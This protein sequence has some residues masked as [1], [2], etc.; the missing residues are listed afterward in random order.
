M[1]QGTTA[2]TR[3]RAECAEGRREDRKRGTR[4][5]G[6]FEIVV[7]LGQLQL[8]MDAGA[9]PHQLFFSATALRILVG[10]E[11]LDEFVDRLL[12][13]SLWSAFLS[14]DARSGQQQSEG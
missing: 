13:S 6:D 10:T 8:V 4:C 5:V 14:N 11:L 3:S 2:W 1:L 7:L 9:K 12:G